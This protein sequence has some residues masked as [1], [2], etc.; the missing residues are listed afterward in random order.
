MRILCILAPLSFLQIHEH[1]LFSDHVIGVSYM[2]IYKE[3]Y[4]NWKFFVNVIV[5]K[6]SVYREF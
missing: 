4:K 6:R 3:I 1:P 2:K 5:T